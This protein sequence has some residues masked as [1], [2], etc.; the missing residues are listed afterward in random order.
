MGKIVAKADFCY[1][2]GT[3]DSAK[4]SSL[5][6]FQICTF[7]KAGMSLRKSAVCAYKLISHVVFS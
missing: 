5:I 6:A 2:R 4:G 3:F 7:Q 1:Q